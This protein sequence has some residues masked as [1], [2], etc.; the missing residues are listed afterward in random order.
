MKCARAQMLTEA[1]ASSVLGTRSFWGYCGL[2]S[3]VP[4]QAAATCFP[5]EHYFAYR[6]VFLMIFELS[7]PATDRLLLVTERCLFSG[8]DGY[9]RAN[10]VGLAFTHISA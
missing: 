5:D 4:P 9:G 8:H 6:V 2:G 10:G 1:Y 3:R 7:D